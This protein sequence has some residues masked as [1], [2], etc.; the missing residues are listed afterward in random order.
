MNQTFPPALSNLAGRIA[1]TTAHALLLR[2]TRVRNQFTRAAH[3]PDQQKDDYPFA[4]DDQTVFAAEKILKR[5]KRNGE[6]QYI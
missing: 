2:I 3:D 5:R 4:I 6:I 1:I